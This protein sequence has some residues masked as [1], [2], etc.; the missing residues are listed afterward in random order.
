MSYGDLLRQYGL[1]GS[2]ADAQPSCMSEW[3]CPEHGLICS[4]V[5]DHDGNHLCTQDDE[6]RW[7][8]ARVERRVEGRL[9]ALID[10]TPDED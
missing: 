6:Y 5:H 4:L 3:A 7:R 9:Q 2:G 8:V 10:T 1:P